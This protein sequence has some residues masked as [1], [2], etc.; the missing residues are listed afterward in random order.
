MDLDN[1][2]EGLEVAFYNL[3]RGREWIPIWFYSQYN[4]SVRSVQN[5]SLGEIINSR[6]LALRGHNV[7]Y[8]V[9]QND[10][11]S[12]QNIA[13]I[14]L[15][16][17][18]VFSVEAHAGFFNWQFRWQQTVAVDDENDTDGDIIHINNVTIVVVNKT[19]EQRLTI[20]EDDLQND[21]R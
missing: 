20:F 1:F 18:N 6:Y 9:A 14:R 15:C 13:N 7:R 5:I 19:N 8:T 2:D 4:H 11:N 3:N 17:P 21:L 16:G 10:S 12:T